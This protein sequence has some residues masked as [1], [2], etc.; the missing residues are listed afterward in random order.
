MTRLACSLLLLCLGPVALAEPGKLLIVGGALAPD[1]AEIHKTFIQAAPAEG[2]IFVIPLASGYPAG[3]AAN[4]M[5]LMENYGADAQRIQL[6]P[7]A[8]MDDPD[9]ADV[10]EANWADNLDNPRVIRALEN[11][12]GVWFTGG[13][14]ARITALLR[15]DG[16]D[17][18][19]LRAIRRAFD[20]GAVIGGTSAGAAIMSDPMILFGD[21]LPSLFGAEA[22]EEAVT[23]GPGLGFFDYGITDQHFDA[24]A[25]LGR[26]VV[27]LSMLPEQSQRIGFGVDENT[28]MLV[29]SDGRFEVLGEAAVTIL[30]GRSASFGSTPD[31]AAASHMLLH[32]LTRGDSYN[33]LTGEFSIASYKDPTVGNEYNSRVL[34]GGGGIALPPASTIDTLGEALL[35]NSASSQ[36]ERL[37]FNDRGNLAL[38][39]FEQ[40]GNSRGY[41]GRDETNQARYSITGVIYSVETN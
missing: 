7:L 15:P 6:M 28:G 25:R 8:V 37:S 18:D 16:A 17:T 38:Y 39:R 41:W 12:A 27:A 13:D 34:P 26:L 23:L 3:S 2:S 14:Q 20:T 29:H 33:L 31:K 11:A 10:D 22:G 36:I 9:T 5:Q 1:N 40:T 30:D 21:T 24:R 35:D 4:F 32:M 19:T